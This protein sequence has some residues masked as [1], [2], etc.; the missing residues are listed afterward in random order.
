MHRVAKL[1]ALAPYPKLRSSAVTGLLRCEKLEF[2]IVKRLKFAPY[3]PFFKLNLLFVRR[4][5]SA[6]TAL[7][8]K[9]AEKIRQ[10]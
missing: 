9:F 1:L 6:T 10:I 7:S 2:A 3:K 5:K 4:I 8:Y